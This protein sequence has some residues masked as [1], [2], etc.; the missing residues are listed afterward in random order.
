MQ[1]FLLDFTNQNLNYQMLSLTDKQV[2]T[3]RCFEFKDRRPN[4]GLQFIT[5]N[6]A[7]EDTQLLLFLPAEEKSLRKKQKL[8]SSLTI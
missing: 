5:Y 7:I 4:K 8:L 3:R 6:F 2:K 1:L